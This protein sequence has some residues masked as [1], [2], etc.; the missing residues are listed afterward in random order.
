MANF[1]G[2]ARSNYFAVKDENAFQEEM[3]LY[4]VE[5]ITKEQDGVTLYGFLDSDQNGGADVWSFY[6]DETDEYEEILWS[7]IFER[8]LQDNWVAV[9]VDVGSESYRYFTGGATAFNNK[10][11]VR[12]VQLNDIYKLAEGLGSNTTVAEY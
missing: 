11:E 3:K 8:H 5:V 4:P 12:N 2:Y 10:G 7:A 9:I 6:N 1:V